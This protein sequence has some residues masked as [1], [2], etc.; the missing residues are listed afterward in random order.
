MS[1]EPTWRSP[2]PA[3]SYTPQH[4]S[5]SFSH[6]LSVFQTAKICQVGLHR[7][8]S[9]PSLPL[10]LWEILQTVSA[11]LREGSFCT[12]YR[13]YLDGFEISNAKEHL[14]AVSPWSKSIA[15]RCESS[16]N[17]KALSR[18]ARLFSFNQSQ[19][20]LG[21]DSLTCQGRIN[22]LASSQEDL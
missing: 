22:L 1:H 2:F 7:P 10:W 16:L 5:P 6:P 17:P 13:V 11:Y 20:G 9:M 4:L 12:P 19:E 14:I 15:K 18:R 3:S 8:H 21:H